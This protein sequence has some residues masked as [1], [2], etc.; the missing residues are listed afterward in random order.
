MSSRARAPLFYAAFALVAGLSFVAVNA[1]FQV[2]DEVGHYWRAAA[3]AEGAFA[4]RGGAASPSAH[5]PRGVK[6]IVAATWVDT[7]GKVDGT[8]GLERLRRA[9][10]I[11][12]QRAD[13]VLVK[14]PAFYTPVP[15]LP[16]ATAFWAGSRLNAKPLTTFYAGRV[17]NLVVMI[18]LICAAM[19]LAPK[20]AWMFAAAGALPMTLHLAGSL[21]PDAF[22]LGAASVAL[23]LAVTT[24]RFA[25]ARYVAAAA[26]FALLLALCKPVYFLLPLIAIWNG[27]AKGRKVAAAAVLSIAI[28]AGVVL[29]GFAASR[30]T[31]NMRGAVDVDSSRQLASLAT[32][33]LRFARAVTGD[34]A[35]NHARYRHELVGRLGWLD[36]GLPAPL[37][38]L[39]QLAFLLAAVTAARVVSGPQRGVA[40]LAILGTLLLIATSQYLVWTAVG[41]TTIEG[42]QGRYFIPLVA[43][44][45][46]VLQGIEHR[47]VHGTTLVVLYATIGALDVIG[48]VRVATRYF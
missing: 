26:G 29:S 40:L 21:S 11:E 22:T 46:V 36:V 17:A 45:A 5:V 35:V 41:A 10:A 33:P 39:A 28:F 7:A 23:A 48:I 31:F 47:R 19:V 1:P 38:N 12:L 20:A 25:P 34:Y 6:E 30:A 2:P 42:I 37:S 8:V 16:Q 15:Y 27:N 9:R 14:F 18:A 32:A 24:I 3:I 43:V 44:A 13:P 4:P